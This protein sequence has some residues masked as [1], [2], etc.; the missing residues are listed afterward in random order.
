[1]HTVK[2][3]GILDTRQN[4]S[5]LQNMMHYAGSWQKQIII[6]GGFIFKLTPQIFCAQHCASIKYKN[7]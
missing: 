1:M 4:K 3:A 2:G 7:E 5:H 6:S